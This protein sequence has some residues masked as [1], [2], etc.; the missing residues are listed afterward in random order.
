MSDDPLSRC[1]GENEYL[2]HQ[3]DAARREISM[4]SSGKGGRSSSVS[5]DAIEYARS[6]GWYCFGGGEIEPMEE[7]ANIKKLKTE[8]DVARRLLCNEIWMKRRYGHNDMTCTPEKVAEEYQWDCFGAEWK[9][10]QEAMERLAEFD[11]MHGLE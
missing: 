5:P 3:L 9:K 7:M 4:L 1:A 2:K 6:R 11:R 8:R 10:S